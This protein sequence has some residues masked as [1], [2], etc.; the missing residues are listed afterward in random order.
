MCDQLRNAIFI[1]TTTRNQISNAVQQTTIDNSNRISMFMQIL[2][3]HLSLWITRGRQL[4]ITIELISEEVKDEIFIDP[5]NRSTRSRGIIYTQVYMYFIL[6]SFA[7]MNALIL[8]HFP[9]LDLAAVGVGM[10]HLTRARTHGTSPLINS[11]LMTIL[12]SFRHMQHAFVPLTMLPTVDSVAAIN[13]SSENHNKQINNENFSSQ[14]CAHVSFRT[15]HYSTLNLFIGF[16][17]CT[18]HKQHENSRAN[19]DVGYTSIIEVVHLHRDAGMHFILIQIKSFLELILFINFI[20]IYISHL[21]VNAQM[22]SINSCIQ[23]EWCGVCS[24]N[25][26]HIH[27]TF[28]LI[29]P[30]IV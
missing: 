25:M 2:A 10:I 22:T 4:T 1:D 20:W 12:R 26:K 19:N 17:V 5:I 14:T 18:E 29:H 15:T 6:K 24:M 21:L 9:S 7:G 11:E 16:Y 8:E 3:A 28:I 27:T 23:I 13:D 30:A